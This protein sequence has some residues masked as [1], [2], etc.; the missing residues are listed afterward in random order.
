[1]AAVL[2]FCLISLT[3]LPPTAG[4]VAKLYIFNA[5][6]QSDLVWL[7]IVGVLNSVVSAFY[8]LRVVRHMYLAPAP[9]E[10]DIAP[11][12][13]LTTALAVTVTGVIVI[14]LVPTPLI[15][16]AQRAVTALN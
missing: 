3:G 14:G 7:V 1:M 2:A 12:P 15:D 4:F 10:G 8:Y 11:G 16:A 5:A 6:V 13:W 9:S